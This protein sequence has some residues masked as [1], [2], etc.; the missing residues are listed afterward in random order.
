[1]GRIKNKR[2]GYYKIFPEDWQIA[3]VG[4]LVKRIKDEVKVSPSTIYREIGIRSHGKGIFHKKEVLGETL[5][6]KSVFWVKPDCFIVNIVFAWELA[7]AKTTINEDGFIASHRFPMY[8][9]L[10]DKLDLDFLLYYFK[11]PFGKHLLNLASPGGAGRNKTLGQIEFSKLKL[12]IPKDIKEQQKIAE[13]LSTWDEAISLKQ[14]L[15]DQK[16]AQKKSLMQLLLTGKIRVTEMGKLSS[17]EIKK[18]ITEINQGNVP[19]SYKKTKVGIIPKKWGEVKLKDHLERIVGGGTPSRNN[20]EYWRGEIPWV[21]VKDLSSFNPFETQEYIT[22][23]GLRHSSSNLIAR[24]TI[25]ISTRMA[26][27]KAV[28]YSIDVSINQDLKALFTKPT[29]DSKYLMCWFELNAKRIN[30]IGTGSTVKGI[31]LSDLRNIKLALPPLP[32]QQKI[33]EILS[34]VDKEVEFLKAELEQL[35]EQKK[36]LMQLLLTGKIRVNENLSNKS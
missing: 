17:E 3:S 31:Q 12:C 23:E 22:Q 36:G 7:I 13:I 2:K 20:K 27:G 28:T 26:L 1:M 29:I 11:T 35:K 25:I 10:E 24:D 30:S 32:E 8:A 16:K 21:T 19:E 9:P 14:Q 5:G 15:I 33:T 18:R 34:T 6:N 4:S